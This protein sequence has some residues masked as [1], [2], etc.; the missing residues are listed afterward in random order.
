MTY[1]EFRED[2]LNGIKTF[3]NDWREGQ[4]YLTTLILN[5]MQLEKYNLIMVQI[6]SIEMI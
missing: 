5:I 2:V 1:E 3:Q 6:V 4:R